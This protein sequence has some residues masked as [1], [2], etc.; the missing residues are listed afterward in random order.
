[1][2]SNNGFQVAWSDLYME[3]M[4]QGLMAVTVLCL[5]ALTLWWL[6]RKGM[7]TFVAG[8]RTAHTRRLQAL[9]R[10]PLTAQHSLHLVRAAG[11]V[12]LISSSPSGCSVLERWSRQDFDD[13][14]RDGARGNG[15]EVVR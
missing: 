11:K 4:Q 14:V 1:V 13:A 12:V 15:A 6:R 2:G 10:L 8:R 3:M 9:E 7:A 5:L